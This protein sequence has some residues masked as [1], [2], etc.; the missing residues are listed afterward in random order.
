MVAAKFSKVFV[1]LRR[2]EILVNLDILNVHLKISGIPTDKVEIKC[3]N[4]HISKWDKW[5]TKSKPQQTL[6][7]NKEGKI[8]ISTEIVGQVENKRCE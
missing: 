2:G 1:L 3:N 5:K 7:L 8:K 6:I 4:F